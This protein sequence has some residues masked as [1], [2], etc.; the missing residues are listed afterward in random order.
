MIKLKEKVNKKF[1]PTNG[2]IYLFS[3][4][5]TLYE[6]TLLAG[7]MS[8]RIDLYIDNYSLI[9]QFYYSTTTLKN[10]PMFLRFSF[11]NPMVNNIHWLK[12]LLKKCLLL[13]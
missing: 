7:G 3:C 10:V 11:D 9:T 6:K 8:N 5:L 12:A 13:K 4:D 2:E 1:A